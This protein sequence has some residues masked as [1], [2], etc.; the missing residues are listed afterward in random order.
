MNGVPSWPVRFALGL[1]G[2]RN[3][4]RALELMAAMEPFWPSAWVE[5]RFLEPMAPVVE[6]DRARGARV[7][8][9][10]QVSRAGAN[11][12][13]YVNNLPDAQ[14]ERQA[15]PTRRFIGFIPIAR[16]RAVYFFFGRARLDERLDAGFAHYQSTHGRRYVVR[17]IAY[18]CGRQP[19]FSLIFSRIVAEDSERK[20]RFELRQNFRSWVR[21]DA[22]ATAPSRASPGS[23]G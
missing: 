17:R 4:A 2:Q 13:L 22:V 15:D 8:A 3:Y 10:V 6:L 7:A 5:I 23:G 9:I 18:R 11:E 20:L 1:I 16:Y 21:L 14:T 19:V 12:R